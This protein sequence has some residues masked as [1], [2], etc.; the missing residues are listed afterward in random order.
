MI[1]NRNF[2]IIWL[3]SVVLT[4]IACAARDIDL[5]MII[6]FTTLSAGLFLAD[7]WKNYSKLYSR[8]SEFKR[9]HAW[10]LI[11]SMGQIFFWGYLFLFVFII[12]DKA[13]YHWLIIADLFIITTYLNYKFESS[14]KI[15]DIHIVSK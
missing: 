6:L 8:S 13:W 4:L 9:M 11:S 15:L 3:I 2:K 12:V 10:N 1:Y 5:K 7:L 14:I